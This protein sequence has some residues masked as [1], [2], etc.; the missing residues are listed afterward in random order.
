MIAQHLAGWGALV[1][2]LEPESVQVELARL[3]A[4]LVRRYAPGRQPTQE[5]D[6]MPSDEP[7]PPLPDGLSAPVLQ[8]LTATGLTD[9]RRVAEVTEKELLALHGVGPKTIVTLRPAL[10]RHGLAFRS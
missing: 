6:P 1:E 2:V 3:G 7:A 9:L 10:D 5:R 8:A 4:E